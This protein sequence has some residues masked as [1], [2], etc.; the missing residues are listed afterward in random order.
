MSRTLNCRSEFS[1]M[2]S[3]HTGTFSWHNL[4]ERRNVATQ[5]VR[6]LIINVIKSV[7]AKETIFW[8]FLLVSSLYHIG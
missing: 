4:P 6:V 3:A 2:P 8:N 5:C 1:L 7:H